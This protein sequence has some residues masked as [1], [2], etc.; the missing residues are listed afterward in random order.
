MG[1]VSCQEQQ[2]QHYTTPIPLTHGL[3][4]PFSS[5]ANRQSK[6]E[7]PPPTLHRDRPWSY[8][9]NECG[10][11]R[12]ERVL[13]GQWSWRGGG[14]A[15]SRPSSRVGGAWSTLFIMVGWGMFNAFLHQW[16]LGLPY[17]LLFRMGA[18]STTSFSPAYHAHSSR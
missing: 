11:L 15:C 13:C 1:S 18:R 2:Q 3:I 5:C 10:V 6:K 9:H 7:K 4:R 8:E 14:G 17:L 16:R 12:A